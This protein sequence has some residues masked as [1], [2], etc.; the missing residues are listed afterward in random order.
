[1][2]KLIK[3]VI[4]YVIHHNQV[5]SKVLHTALA[6]P[7]GW[8]YLSDFRD[9][10]EPDFSKEQCVRTG[11]PRGRCSAKRSLE[12]EEETDWSQIS[13]SDQ[14]SYIIAQPHASGAVS[15]ILDGKCFPTRR[16]VLTWAHQPLTYFQNWRN[17]SVGNAS[18]AWRRCL[19]R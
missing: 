7:V 5:I 4:P 18:E 8:C 6:R 15:E 17:H 3:L 12:M 2:E 9:R 10:C 13:R 14:R 19:M 1:M 11:R 16:T